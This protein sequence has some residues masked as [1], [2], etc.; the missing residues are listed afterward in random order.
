MAVK[1]SRGRFAALMTGVYL[2]AAFAVVG[3]LGWLGGR[4]QD[5]LT[6]VLRAAAEA[7]ETV[8]TGTGTTGTVA[9]STGSTEATS[10]ATQSLPTETVPAAEE[11]F[12]FVWMSDTQ[13][14]SESFPDIFASMTTWIEEQKESRNI[15]YVLHTGDVVNNRLREGQWNNALEAMNKL[16]VPY[17]VAAGNHDVGTPTG[18]YQYFSPRFGVKTPPQGGLW[19]EGKGQYDLLSIGGMD[20]LLL[21]LG[22][23]NGDAGIEWTNSILAQYPDHYAILG[24]HSYMHETGVLTTIGKG[25]YE[26]IVVPN[27]N[28]RLVLC[29]HH[30]SAGKRETPLDDDGDGQPDRTVYQLLADYQAAGQGG[31]GFM[32]LLTFDT[33]AKML[34]VRTYSPYL[35]KTS[36]YDDPAIDTFDLPLT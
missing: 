7:D 32:R 10:T 31:G 17:L 14:Y 33:A 3:G 30:H 13:L 11:P 1:F 5:W 34:Q 23:G 12:T 35:D 15:R 24:F 36:F 29:G 2:V 4:G 28:V 25:L 26:K 20:I 19:E 27:P 6:V 21:F 16:T 18:D 9:P 8:S 22:Y